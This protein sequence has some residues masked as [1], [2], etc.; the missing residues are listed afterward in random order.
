MYVG[1]SLHV[2]LTQS[3]VHFRFTFLDFMLSG[4]TAVADASAHF[5]VPVCL[6]TICQTMTRLPAVKT[7]LRR[8]TEEKQHERF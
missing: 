4:A 8:E 7:Q 5:F 1:V 3:R 6:W 2:I